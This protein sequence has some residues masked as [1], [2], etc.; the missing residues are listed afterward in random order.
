[1]LDAANG[2]LVCGRSVGER[3]RAQGKLHLWDERPAAAVDTVVVHYISAG[4]VPGAD[5]FSEEQ[6]LAVFCDF[7]VSSHYLIGRDGSVL[8]LV[9][10]AERAWHCG[11]SIMPSPDE[12]VGVNDFSIGVELVATADSGY[13]EA[14]YRAL[15]ALGRGL[16]ERLGGPLR[17][18]GHEHVAGARAVAMGLRAEPKTDPGPLFDWNKARGLLGS[19]DIACPPSA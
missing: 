10:E 17:Y 4:D 5:P 11:G 15:G 12:R 8:R 14:Q 16:A 3:V 6:I 18:V 19:S 9:P 13:T 1:M 7:G 2:R